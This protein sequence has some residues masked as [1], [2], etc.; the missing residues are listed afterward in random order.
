[1]RTTAALVMPRI[2]SEPA[3][4]SPAAAPVGDENGRPGDADQGGGGRQRQWDG[5]A[6]AGQADQDGPG[7]RVRQE[8]VGAD[9]VADG[10]PADAADCT[11]AVLERVAVGVMATSTGIPGSPAHRVCRTIRCGGRPTAA[12]G[13]G[14]TTE[15]RFST[16]TKSFG[17]SSRADQPAERSHCQTSGG[18]GSAVSSMCWGTVIRAARR[19][20]PVPLQDAG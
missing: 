16:L 9:R 12:R 20:L 17:R 4:F 18:R 10:E 2:S 5:S 3:H 1:M 15:V 14:R 19:G 6:N 8:H 7:D 11:S 13:A